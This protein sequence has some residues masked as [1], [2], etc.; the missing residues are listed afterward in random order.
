M[1]ARDFDALTELPLA[2][3]DERL[4]RYRL[5]TPR[6]EEAMRQ[7]LGRYGQLSPIVV[8]WHEEV[9]VLIDGFK[10]LRAARKLKGMTHLQ[11]RLLPLDEQATETL[12]Q[13]GRP[14]LHGTLEW[15]FT[16]TGSQSG[17]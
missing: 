16:A 3:I 7:S 13:S 14:I 17:S 9:P 2:G 4:Q 8:C 10:R 1:D 12:L 11:A 5:Q 6:A 15:S